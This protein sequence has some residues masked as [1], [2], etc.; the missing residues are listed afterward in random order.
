M[1]EDRLPFNLRC[2]LPCRDR[3]LK[4]GNEILTKI[5]FKCLKRGVYYCLHIAINEFTGN[6]EP[7][8]ENVQQAITSD[9]PNQ[10]NAS[11]R[12]MLKPWEF[13]SRREHDGNLIEV[14]NVL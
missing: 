3:V 4:R 8:S 13:G 9:E 1:P 14:G 7:L 10:Y 2:L 11:V 5:D 12:D 6:F